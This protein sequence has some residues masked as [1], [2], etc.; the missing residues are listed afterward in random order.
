VQ[1][2]RTNET[3]TSMLSSEGYFSVDANFSDFMANPA[4]PW[5]AEN[6][7]LIVEARDSMGTNSTTKFPVN[8][9]FDRQE[10]GLDLS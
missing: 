4:S 2:E 1:N 10:V 6:D 3:K 7:T 5:I 8:M 9:C